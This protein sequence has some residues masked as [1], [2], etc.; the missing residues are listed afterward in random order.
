MHDHTRMQYTSPPGNTQ[1][2]NINSPIKWEDITLHQLVLDNSNN[3]MS[4]TFVFSSS[5]NFLDDI[6]N[7][8]R[9]Y[10]ITPGKRMQWFGTLRNGTFHW[11][12]S[13]ESTN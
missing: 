2:V 11:R 8:T 12:L 7:T 13:E 10:I 3:S 1:T 4:K 5:H 6:N 9:T